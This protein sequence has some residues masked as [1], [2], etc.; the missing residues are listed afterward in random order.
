MSSSCLG[1]PCST[2]PTPVGLGSVVLA[3]SVS[4][5]AATLRAL[6]RQHGL[7]PRPLPPGLLS[8]DD[9][10]VDEFVAL[11]LAELS[12][13]EA[14]EVRCLVLPG[15]HPREDVVLHRAMTAPTLAAAGARAK[16]A[17]LMELF[18]DEEACFYA[19]YQPI[20]TL[21]TREVIGFEALL[22]AVTAHGRTLMPKDLFPAAQAAGW[23]HLLD[24]VGR[25]TALRSAG[26]WLPA[27]RQ[28]F[29]NFIPSSI[30][31]PEVCLLTTERAAED[32]G[33]ALD[34]LVFEVTEGHQVRDLRHL[35]RVFDYYR[36]HG[37]KVALDDLGAG[38]SSL[39]LLVSLRPD[40][41]KLD[42][43]I[44][45]GLPG[46][47]SSA[48]VAAVVEIAHSYGGQVL[49]ECVE[50][51]EQA[52][53]ALELGVDLAQGWLFGR[54]E[55]RDREPEHPMTRRSEASDPGP[56]GNP[57]P[58]G[59]SAAVPVALPT[60]LAHVEGDRLP[61][62]LV[63]AVG[64]SAGGVVVVDTGAHDHPMLYVNPAFEAL[65]GYTSAELLGRN[66]R[67]LQGPDSAPDVIRGLSLAIR[68]GEEHRC[69][70]RNYRKDGT[71][72]WN[73]L[74]LSPVRDERG[75]LTHYLGYQHDVTE[76]VEA[77]ARLARQ[78]SSDSLTGLANRTYLLDSL[79]AALLEAE[80]AGRAVAVLFI[81]LDGFK[82][83][84]DGLGH[85]AGDRVLV[86]VADRLRS[87]LRSCDVIGRNGGDEFVAILQGLTP[88][89]ASRIAAR[90]SAGVRAAL[91]RPFVVSDTTTKLGASVGVAVSPTDASSVDGLLLAADADMYRVKKGRSEAIPGS[92][93]PTAPPRTAAAT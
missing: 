58:Q 50:S 42:R 35:E 10:A 25:T 90:A 62:L 93:I 55:S 5:T 71:G 17:D 15:P 40:I 80:S 32:A 26:G 18:A 24:R 63:R 70:L 52:A 72:W 61:S 13:V 38:Y 56:A 20:V 48:V 29:I 21:A 92:R 16:Y 8:L 77:Q 30:Y 51:P 76:R 84:N 41:V 34:Q 74:H 37:C 36:S 89:D 60:T 75:R 49:A 86:Q 3:T 78:A 67:L 44:V 9:V 68:R 66:C 39:N 79:E 47:I 65:T 69:V 11:A 1:C 23:L 7:S 57:A 59:P 46:P 6:A 33:I 2:A 28:L 12:P 73:E 19:A 53:R 14:D 82:A 54:P 64:S 4:H 27:N 83:V 81:D 88:S 22:R 85:A 87:V 31:R 45:Q 43:E 91:Q